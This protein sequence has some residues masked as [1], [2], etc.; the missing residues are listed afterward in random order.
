M[1][2]L[3][4]VAQVLLLPLLLVA[5]TGGGSSPSVPARST[6][7][8]TAGPARSGQL[9]GATLLNRISI[10]DMN[11]AIRARGSRTPIVT[12]LY[13][14]TNYRLSYLTTDARG[15]EVVASGLV[16]VPAKPAGARSPLLSYQHATI[17]KDAQAPSN[18][19]RPAEPPVVVASLGYFVMAAD[20]VGYGVSKGTPHPYL[21]SAPSASAV[22]DLLTAASTWRHQNGIA[23]NGQ[24]FLTGYSQ[25]GYVTIAAHR[26]MQ[27][28]GSPYLEN[29]AAVAPGAGPYDAGV[30]LDELLR[31]VRAER[32][33]LGALIDPGLL[34]HLGSSLRRA[35]REALL[36]QLVPADADVVFDT[37]LIDNYLADDA[38]AIERHSNVHDWAPAVP[39]RFFH[40]RDDRT[41]PY[42]SATRTL[43]TMLAR[44]ASDVSLTDCSALPS[45]HKGCVPQFLLFMLGEFATL[46]R[47]L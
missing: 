33:L 4:R 23:D 15:K 26:A 46:A 39:A 9:I 38:A 17:Y 5:A 6:P 44:G 10:A 14:V 41:V 28:S 22:V 40:G 13:D 43:Q 30:T 21:L 29:L 1:F 8:A 7:P 24:L 47:D 2:R 19:P 16:S 45:S 37:T 31:R 25:G 42:V 12:P 20:Y 32:P 36:K 11:Q 3:G 35:V 18:N 34:R 27:A